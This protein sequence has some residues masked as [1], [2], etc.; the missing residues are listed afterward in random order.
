MRERERTANVSWT[1]LSLKKWII[2]YANRLIGIFKFEQAKS[3]Y[4]T[5]PISGSLI[6]SPISA[7]KF[8]RKRRVPHYY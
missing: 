5:L 4:P 8:S 2:E 3:M 7:K 6:T 1:L